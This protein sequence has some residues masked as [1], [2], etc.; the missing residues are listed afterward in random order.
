[1]LS[2]FFT[3]VAQFVHLFLDLGLARRQFFFVLR[4]GLVAQ[5]ASTGRGAIW[6]ARL[7]TDNFYGLIIM[8]CG[9]I[10]FVIIIA[11][12]NVQRLIFVVVFIIHHVNIIVS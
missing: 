10:I 3:E 6:L 1:L 12:M 4:H 8:Y 5:A 11:K 9:G 7:G 2:E